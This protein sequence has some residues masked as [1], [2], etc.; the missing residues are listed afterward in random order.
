M[1]QVQFRVCT[2]GHIMWLMSSWLEVC[3]GGNELCCTS[4]GLLLTI[5][6][7]NY[8]VFFWVTQHPNA[9]SEY[10][11]TQHSIHLYVD[12]TFSVLLMWCCL[13]SCKLCR[14]HT[15]DYWTGHIHVIHV[16]KYCIPDCGVAIILILCVQH[17]LQESKQHTFGIPL[18]ASLGWTVLTVLF[19]NFHSQLSHKCNTYIYHRGVITCLWH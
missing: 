17:N 18:H 3:V 5:G 11:A 8:C 19:V 7:M 13:F 2:H 14:T 1:V 10:I 16:I 12:G 4:A 6:V 9:R 15:I